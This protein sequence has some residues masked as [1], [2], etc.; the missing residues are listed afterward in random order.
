MNIP[1]FFSGEY[2]TEIL[3]PPGNYNA[4]VISAKEALSVNN[5]QTI[6][7]GLEIIDTEYAGKVIYDRFYLTS[8]ALPR[9]KNF[10]EAI[11]IYSQSF[12]L[13]D[14]LIL[15]KICSVDVYIDNFNSRSFNRVSFAGYSKSNYREANM[16][17]DNDFYDD[18]PF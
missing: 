6:I 3:L 2:G 15:N 10:L 5:I 18:I 16:I 4:K 8:K 12:I 14:N 7:I 13:T 9:L 1:V 17:N 11:G